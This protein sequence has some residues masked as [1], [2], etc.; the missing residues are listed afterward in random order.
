[1]NATWVRALVRAA[2]LS[3]AIVITSFTAA[4]PAAPAAEGTSA[5]PSKCAAQAGL[6][7]ICG[8]DSPEDLVQVGQTPWVITSGAGP[9]GGLYLLKADRGLWKQIFPGDAVPA[10]LD[11]A[12]FSAC[13]G[14]P[15]AAQLSLLG[16]GLRPDPS[17]PQ[18]NGI[19][20][21]YRLYAVDAGRNAIE[22][23]N[24]RLRPT[25]SFGGGAPVIPPPRLTWVGCVML[26]HGVHAAGVTATSDGTIF[27]SVLARPGM[28]LAEA[29]SGKP[30]GAVYA[31]KPGDTAFHELKGTELPGDAGLEISSDD[32]TLYVVAAGS[33]KI[34]AFSV[35]DPSHPLR[36]AQLQGFH[37]DSLHWDGKDLV[38]A[39]MRTGGGKPDCLAA[40][41]ASTGADTCHAGYMAARIDPAS[42]SV[43]VFAQGAPNPAYGDVSLALPVAH[44]LWVGSLHSDRLAYRSL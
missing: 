35:A 19:T 33:M 15:A 10:Q 18:A 12:H 22:V 9:H 2:A 37:P 31:W 29:F 28:S 38:T 6:H 43:M 41:D 4:V 36:S 16:L 5:A 11:A 23:F 34:D 14:P 27:A 39:G 40:A 13:S 44:H 8:I 25:P 7:F 3:A 20:A 24:V 21:A 42:M 1:M 17:V 26:P 32:Q 30:T